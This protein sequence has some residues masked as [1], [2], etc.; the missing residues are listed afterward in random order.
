MTTYAT[1]VLPDLD[2]RAKG[3]LVRPA[4]SSEYQAFRL[5]IVCP[6]EE[7]AYLADVIGM[8]YAVL[9]PA[10]STMIANVYRQLADYRLPGNT[11][12]LSVC[13]L[14]DDLI[15]RTQEV[16]RM[17]PAA[18]GYAHMKLCWHPSLVQLELHLTFAP[19]FSEADLDATR[20]LN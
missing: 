10:L 19:T 6:A 14:A 5:L 18:G 1:E 12:T 2:F 16:L 9:Y 11:H 17:F 13:M 3:A 4:G 15:R 7:Q 20:V 8:E